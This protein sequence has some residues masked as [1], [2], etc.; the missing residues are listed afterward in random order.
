MINILHDV[1][2]LQVGNPCEMSHISDAGYAYRSM[3]QA[4]WDDAAECGHFRPRADGS[5][6]RVKFWVRG[7]TGQFYRPD[8][9]RIVIRVPLADWSRDTFV[10]AKVAEIVM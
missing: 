4:E 6:R 7:G 10:S 2:A 5:G 9:G 1:P 3:D 8:S